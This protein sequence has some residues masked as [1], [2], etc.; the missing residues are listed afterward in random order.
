MH[1]L[2]FLIWSFL[3]LEEQLNYEEKTKAVAIE[4]SFRYDSACIK[5]D[6]K[7]KRIL[8]LCS[9]FLS[10]KEYNIYA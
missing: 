1:G 2:I 5:L 8:L 9:I 3:V 4:R 6:E 10:L 7:V